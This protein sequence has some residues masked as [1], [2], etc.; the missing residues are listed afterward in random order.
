MRNKSLHVVRQGR[1]KV[2][3]FPRHRVLKDQPVGVEGGPVD[4]VASRPI[5][6]V[7]GKGIS[8][9]C[10]MDPQLMGAARLGQQPQQ[11]AT[12]GHRQGLVPRQTLCSVGPDTVSIGGP[13]FET[14]VPDAGVT[15]PSATARY[16]R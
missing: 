1:K 5:E 7:P 15:I 10:H 11:G 8:K 6:P 13:L 14:T 16:S 12:V 9:M 4:G 3:L 2:Q